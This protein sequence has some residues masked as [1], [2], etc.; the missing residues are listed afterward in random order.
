MVILTFILVN[1]KAEYDVQRYCQ[2][3]PKGTKF[4]SFDSCQT[5]YTCLSAYDIKESQCPNGEIFDKDQQSCVIGD[6]STA[7]K[8]NACKGVH[9]DFAAHASDCRVWHY[10]E[11]DEIVHTAT[12]PSGQ[13]FNGNMC[14]YGKCEDENDDEVKNLCKIMQINQFFGDF[15][16]CNAWRKCKNQAPIAVGHCPG[17]TVSFFFNPFTT[18]NRFR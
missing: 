8:T 11:D 17:N 16:N 1:V 2:L 14:V 7:V 18:T 15:D 6:C 9:K 5:Y 12:C 3:V 13:Y 4:P 10:C